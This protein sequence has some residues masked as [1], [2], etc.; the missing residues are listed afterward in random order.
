MKHIF[1]AFALT[2]ILCAVGC[3]SPARRIDSGGTETIT[4]IDKINVADFNIAADE[5]IQSMLDAGV[6]S[7][8]QS[9]PVIMQ[10]GRIKNSTT[11]MINMSRLTSRITS[12]LNRSKIAR[13]LATDS[14]SKEL[15]EY[16]AAIKG[17]ET[18][19]PEIILTGEIIEDSVRAGRT[20][21][22]T[23]MFI[24]RLNINGVSAWEDQTEITKQGTR[25]AV[26]W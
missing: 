2:G 1:L 24:L 26:G 23:Y 11:D 21:E 20:K 9:K 4:S 7:E 22:T 12:T 5:L 14:A 15:A 13:V 10:V 8:I 25:A 18:P 3:S 19:M 17:T 16:N 6:F